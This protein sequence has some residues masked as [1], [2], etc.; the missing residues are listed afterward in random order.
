MQAAF[1]GVCGS[2]YMRSIPDLCRLRAMFVLS[3]SGCA[4]PG[5]QEGA[6]QAP[7]ARRPSAGGAGF[8]GRQICQQLAFVP[9]CFLSDH[10]IFSVRV[11]FGEFS[12]EKY[13][14]LR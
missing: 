5:G 10:S 7:A 2:S 12:K 11:H 1:E 14:F 4:V 9:A 6:R 8:V 3:G 13:F